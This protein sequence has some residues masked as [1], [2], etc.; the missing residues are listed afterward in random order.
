MTDRLLSYFKRL[1]LEVIYRHAQHVDALPG[2]GKLSAKQTD[3]VSGRTSY[4][5][6]K[7]VHTDVSI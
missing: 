7:E 1:S 5:N 3:E 6:I 4:L 2:E